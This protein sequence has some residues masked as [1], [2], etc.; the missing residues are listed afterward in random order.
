MQ[1]PCGGDTPNVFTDLQ[2]GHCGGGQGVGDRCAC[3]GPGKGLSVSGKPCRFL[4]HQSRGNRNR[5]QVRRLL[6]LSS[7]EQMGLVLG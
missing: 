7:A 4:N 3:R 5:I 2:E 6:R 1:R